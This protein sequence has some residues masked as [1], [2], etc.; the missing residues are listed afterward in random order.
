[1]TNDAV[2]NVQTPVFVDGATVV[3]EFCIAKEALVLGGVYVALLLVEP[4]A[5]DAQG[6]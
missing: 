5:K 4:T 2:G 1:M 6:V 3:C